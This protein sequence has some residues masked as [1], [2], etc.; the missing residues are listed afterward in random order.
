MFKHSPNGNGMVY[1]PN[2]IYP[3]MKMHYGSN[4]IRPSGKVMALLKIVFWSVNGH[5]KR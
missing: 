3:S 4:R 1:G 2:G 5:G